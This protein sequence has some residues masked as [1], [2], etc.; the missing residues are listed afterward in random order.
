MG[1]CLT[2][3]AVFMLSKSTNKLDFSQFL[4]LIRTPQNCL[5]SKATPIYI[6]LDHASAH[7]NHFANECL[8]VLN[9]VPLWM[10]TYSPELNSIEVLWGHIKRELG[11]AHVKAAMLGETS[12]TD[13]VTIANDTLN[14]FRNYD[15]C[16]QLMQ[17]NRRFVLKT[18]EQLQL[19]ES[20]KKP[21]MMGSDEMVLL[22]RSQTMRE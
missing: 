16:H 17:S 4:K 10:P 14:S 5:L 11:M 6:V 13:F 19:R 1:N 15:F 20:R 7:V 22:A 2:N 18:L 12:E 3:G 8:K 9:F 21:G